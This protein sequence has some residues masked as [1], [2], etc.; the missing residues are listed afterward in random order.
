MNY[1]G[2]KEFDDGFASS[3]KIFFPRY[4]FHYRDFKVR[5]DNAFS[6]SDRRERVSPLELTLK[7]R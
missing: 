1:N 3:A 6:F 7:R 5:T 4:L 2:R